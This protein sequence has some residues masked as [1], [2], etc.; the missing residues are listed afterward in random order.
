MEQD[1]RPS[2]GVFNEPSTVSTQ[3]LTEQFDTQSIEE[4]LVWLFHYIYVDGIVLELYRYYN[5]R[6]FMLRWYTYYIIHVYTI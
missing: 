2:I 1:S 4:K 3:E 6:I 5:Y